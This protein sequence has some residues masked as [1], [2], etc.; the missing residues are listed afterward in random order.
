MQEP[1]TRKTGNQVE[2]IVT[3]PWQSINETYERITKHLMEHIEVAGFR[4]GKAPADL[5]KKHI[6]DAKVYEE[7]L[8]ELIPKVYADSVKAHNLKPILSPKVEV[9]EA[10]K[11]KP[12]K[13][14]I[15]TAEK[16]PITLGNYRQAITKMKSAKKATVI[17]P[18]KENQKQEEV[19]LAD[20]L[21][22][23][24][25]EI[26]VEL[27]EILVEQE[28]TRMLSNLVDQ[29]QKLGLTVEHYLQSQGKTSDA[30]REEYKRDA[31]KTLSLEFA[32]EEIADKEN[33]TIDNK[34][35]D[36]F[37]DQAKS[38]QDKKAL[39]DQR[40]YIANLLRRQKT[41]AALLESPIVT[42]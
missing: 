20:V 9:I 16:P 11:E 40:Y 32:L 28:V 31:Q 17:V 1:L 14:K 10:D 37:I 38:A 35:I 27:P 3:L 15:V 6:D 29:T 39:T 34:D 21:D 2:W 36:V 24:A 18:G 33:I 30:L 25:A 12:W 22:A 5:A 41:V 26:K 7:V 8:K 13:F 4:K 23:L 19:T 42:G